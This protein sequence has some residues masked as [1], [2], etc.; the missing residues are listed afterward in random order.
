[1]DGEEIA[2]AVLAREE[3]RDVAIHGVQRGEHTRVAHAWRR[4]RRRDDVKERPERARV[5]AQM[6]LGGI[7]GVTRAPRLRCSGRSGEHREINRDSRAPLR[8][9]ALHHARCL[10]D[11]A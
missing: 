7:A 11:R 5:T 2:P 9:G 4:R 6:R 10:R 3:L 1:M 8:R